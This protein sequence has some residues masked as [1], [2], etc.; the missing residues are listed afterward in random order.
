MQTITSAKTSLRQ[1]PALFKRWG[2]R[3]GGVNLDVGGGAYDEGTHYLSDRHDVANLILDPYNR[4][5]EWN[6]GAQQQFDMLKNVGHE[7]SATL[8]NVL[9]V[10]KG[11]ANRVGILKIIWGKLPKGGKLFV[12]IYE[13]NSSGV[14]KV[15]SKGWQE[16]R[17]AATYLKEIEAVGFNLVRKNG[18]LMEFVK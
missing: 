2:D 11:K 8:C 7:A 17:K 18:N 10:V 16:N 6:H 9:N 4:S 12:S 1:V 3:L 13:G 14:G 5:R 15:T